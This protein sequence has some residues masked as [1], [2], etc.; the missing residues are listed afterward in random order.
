METTESNKTRKPRK[1]TGKKK[2]AKRMPG[3]RGVL[4]Q[5]QKFEEN[6]LV[7]PLPKK[8]KG[9]P[10]KTHTIGYRN[11]VRKEICF[12]KKEQLRLFQASFI[13]PLPIHKPGRRGVLKKL[14]DFRED[15][16]GP[17]PPNPNR[18]E[19]DEVEEL[20]RMFQASFV[21][22]LQPRKPGRPKGS[23]NKRT[24]VH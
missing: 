6:E 13:G 23:F 15:F 24:Y 9:A 14:R 1:S 5:L 12:N 8:H 10:L 17:L 19:I 11:G 2:A 3:R 21:G 7:G 18:G 22:P 16:I 20:V 4:N